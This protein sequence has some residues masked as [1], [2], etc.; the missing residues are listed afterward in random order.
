MRILRV[1]FWSALI[2]SGTLFL[3]S[4]PVY[5]SY[6]SRGELIQRI[7]PHDEAIAELLGE[8]GTPIGSPLVMIIDDQRAFL[9]GESPEGVKLVSEP[10][11]QENGIYPLQL[12]TVA[13]VTKLVRIGTAIVFGLG[14]LGIWLTGRKLRRWRLDD[15]TLA[16]NQ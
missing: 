12:K 9:S 4:I 3:A 5:Q 16:V 8:I 6:A 7:E 2:L 10:Y 15:S 14:S 13:Y 11:L 1:L